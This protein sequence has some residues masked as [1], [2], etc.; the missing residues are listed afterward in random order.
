MPIFYKMTKLI[1]QTYKV[2]QDIPFK[3]KFYRVISKFIIKL[4]FPFNKSV[5][6]N[7]FLQMFQSYQELNVNN[8]TL[9]IKDGNERLHL[10]SNTQFIIEKDLVNWI[11]TFSKEDL[12]LDIG[13]NVGMFSIYAAEKGINTISCEAH[14]A[15]L[16][17]FLYNIH[18][19]ELQE[20]ITVLP[21]LLND[22][23]KQ[24]EFYLRDLTPSSAR[25]TIEHPHNHF[26]NAEKESIRIKT[27]GFSLDNLISNKLISIPSK[28]KIDVDGVELLV[29]RGI[30][31][32]LGYVDEIMLEMYE[33]Y[34]NLWQCFNDNVKKNKIITSEIETNYFEANMNKNPNF[35]E[36]MI[37]LKKYNFKEINSYGNNIIFKNLKRKKF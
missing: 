13:S 20:K 1:K 5:F 8:V 35:N 36:I 30:N 12:F 3:I 37:Y 34:S 7:V 29:L 14:F 32:Y 26:S 22:K 19:N 17:D 18:I 9:K 10:L 16:N 21:F 11:D 33:R 15:N 6:R 2:T 23:D 31:D 4:F 27:L 28:I 25:N 24:E